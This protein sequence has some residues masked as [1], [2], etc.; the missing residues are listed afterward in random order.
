MKHLLYYHPTNREQGH[1][2]RN[3]II[4]C[5]G[6]EEKDALEITLLSIKRNIICYKIISNSNIKPES[7]YHFFS[8]YHICS[9]SLCLDNNEYHDEVNLLQPIRGANFVMI[10]VES[11]IV[12]TLATVKRVY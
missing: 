9:Y 4:L 8:N 5:M 11:Y 2:N 1:Y 7:M 6:K 3:G 12:I 10:S